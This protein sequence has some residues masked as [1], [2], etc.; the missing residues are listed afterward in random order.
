MSE[1]LVD[2]GFTALSLITTLLLCD[3][4]SPNLAFEGNPMP[5]KQVANYM[6]SVTPLSA[7]D[8]PPKF[9]KGYALFFLQRNPKGVIGVMPL[10]SSASQPMARPAIFAP[11]QPQL[12]HLQ[13][14][15][16]MPCK[17]GGSP[18]RANMASRL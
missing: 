4:V 1:Y 5:E 6:T 8:T 17:I 15:Q 12:I 18:L 14:E 7:Y 16:W 2:R 11:S 3:C 9:L 13:R 10:L